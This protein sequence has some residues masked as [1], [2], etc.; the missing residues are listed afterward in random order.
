MFVLAKRLNTFNSTYTG[1]QQFGVS[2]GKFA[3]ADSL[4]ILTND[5]T[6][7]ELNVDSINTVNIKWGNGNGNGTVYWYELN[8]YPTSQE[9]NIYSSDFS[10]LEEADSVVLNGN[11]YFKISIREYDAAQNNTIIN[12]SSNITYTSSILT[13]VPLSSDVIEEY[14]FL[15]TGDQDGWVK[16]TTSGPASQNC[17]NITYN[18]IT[19]NIKRKLNPPSIS[20]DPSICSNS[21]NYTI[22]GDSQSESYTWTTTNGL[23]IYKNGQ[24]LTTYTGTETSLILAN[25][26][27]TSGLSEIKVVAHAQEYIDSGESVKQIWLGDPNPNDFSIIGLD[28]YGNSIDL[29]DG[30]FEVCENEY[31]TFKLAPIYNLPSSHHRYG[32]TDVDFYFDFN[33]TIVTEGYGWAY[34]YV[35]NIDEYSVGLVDVVGCSTINEFLDYGIAE[36]DCGYYFMVYSPNPANEYVDINLIEE[37]DVKDKTNK[38][39]IRKDKNLNAGEIGDYLVQILDKN[40]MIRKS[41]QSN[42]MNTRISTKD[43][44]PGN[45]FLHLTL[46]EEKHKQQI[47]IY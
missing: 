31:Y 30:T 44:E 45:Y 25:P 35:N 33:Y 28:N 26:S 11:S 29:G 21:K 2:N 1:N 40:G 17:P 34:V 42:S 10:I 14:K 32:I 39:K 47:V 22:T 27:S 15:I 18:V 16:F 5:S 24:Y 3:V 6:M 12:K 46:G 7:I 4:Y 13:Q 20:G 43:L 9:I 8:E 38:I 23:K 19:V 37:K 41:V 36:G